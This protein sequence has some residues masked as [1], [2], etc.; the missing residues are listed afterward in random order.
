MKDPKHFAYTKER[1]FDLNN[2]LRTK[3][4]EKVDI[5][6]RLD[7]LESEI[8][9]VEFENKVIRSVLK[10]KITITE[11]TN[12][13]GKRIYIGKYRLYFDPK[14]QLVTIYIGKSEVFSGKDDPKLLEE[15]KSKALI[16][17]KKRLLKM[18]VENI[19]T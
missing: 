1:L 5:Q 9:E 13:A 14:P 3:K 4:S 2:S 12:A 18:G 16:S 7:E 17:N 8:K 6:L 19:F 11:V 15:A 10:P